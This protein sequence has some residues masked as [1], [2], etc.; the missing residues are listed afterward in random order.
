MINAKVDTN[1]PAI[2]TQARAAGLDWLDT[3]R[4][5]DGAPDAIV[6][7]V[8]RWSDRPVSVQVEIKN[9]NGKLTAKEQAYIDAMR[10]PGA[11]IVARDVEDILSWFGMV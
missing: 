5:G 10:Y 7:G 1:H 8:P 3:F 6:S 2:R 4:L 9:G 11:Y